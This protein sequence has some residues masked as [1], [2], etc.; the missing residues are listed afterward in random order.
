MNREAEQ[1]NLR[2]ADLV[3]A[4]DVATAESAPGGGD[5]RKPAAEA[6]A[7]DA[8]AGDKQLAPMFVPDAANE[9][10][11][12]WTAIQ[13]SFVD[14]PKQAV[15]QADELVAQ[16][17]KNLAESFSN[18]RANLEAHLGQKDKVSTEDLRVALRRYRS[19]FERLLSL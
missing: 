1:R 11:T 14:D 8:S 10:R 12:R 3:D 17:M 19:F 2:T 7:H 15:R 6:R 4:A 9:F 18:E 16:V 5:V 13:A